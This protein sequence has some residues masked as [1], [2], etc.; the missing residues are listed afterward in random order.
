MEDVPLYRL[1][2]FRALDIFKYLILSNLK[3][4]PI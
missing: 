3:I 4:K 2:R 1:N